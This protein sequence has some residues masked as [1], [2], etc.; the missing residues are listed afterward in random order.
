LKTE[1]SLLPL[2]PREKLQVFCYLKLVSLVVVLFICEVSPEILGVINL[3]TY[4]DFG[5]VSFISF[6][7]SAFFFRRFK[8]VVAV[9]AASR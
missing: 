1:L 5:E 3:F 7:F 6:T 8:G 2:P 4:G 9:Q